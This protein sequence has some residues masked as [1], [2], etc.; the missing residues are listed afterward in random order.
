M[1]N[2]PSEVRVR[3]APSPTGELHVGGARTALFNWLYARNQGGT[4]ILR[5]EDTDVK[6]SSENMVKGILEGLRWLGLQ[7]DEGPYFQSDRLKFYQITA[8]KLFKEGLAYYCYCSPEELAEERRKAQKNRQLWKYDRRCL[9]LTPSEREEKE[10]KGMQKALRFLVPSGK[11]IF[12]DI[13]RGKIEVDNQTIEDFV[14]LRSDNLPTYHLSCVVDDIEMGINY[15]I[16]GEDHISNT[17][18]QI[19]LYRALAKEPPNFAHLPLILGSDRSRLSKRH[20]ATS[21]LHYREQGF[22]PDAMVNFLALLGWSPGD[23]RTLVDR[24]EL[25]QLFSLEQVSKTSAVFDLQKLEWLNSQYINN[26]K[27][28]ELIPRIKKEL[29]KANI[30]QD[31]FLASKKKWFYQLIE[32][33]KPRAKRLDDFARNGFPFLS[34]N[35]EYNEKA[36]KKYLKVPSL[37]IFIK[38]LHDNFARMESFEEVELERVLRETAYRLDIKAAVLIHATRVALTGQAVSPGI[39]EVLAL[40]GKEKTLARLQ[41]LLDYLSTP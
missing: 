30:W 32:L 28:D 9:K 15:V 41:R 14:L 24:E 33:L 36:V 22:L 40:L 17:P 8:Q 19:L 37:R 20:G 27:I 2:A 38:E 31:D 23:D 34:D 39:F 1:N 26:T 10:K 3:F 11:T 4:F 18:K 6:R 25:I 7:W 29:E 5:I 13:V 16:R 21:L 12:H 35:F